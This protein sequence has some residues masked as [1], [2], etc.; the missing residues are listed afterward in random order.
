MKIVLLCNAGMSTSLLV[1]KMKEAAKSEG[2]DVEISAHAVSEVE[3]AKEADVVL[4]GP[5]I[6]FN[7]SKIQ[8]KLPGIPVECIDPTCYGTMNGKGVLEQVKKILG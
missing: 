4:L 8:A 7:L 3:K 1:N 5:Q 2:L 6:R